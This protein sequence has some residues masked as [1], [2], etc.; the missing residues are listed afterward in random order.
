M[1][2][3]AKYIR[4]IF[5]LNGKCCRHFHI[6]R[7]LENCE[8]YVAQLTVGDIGK[9]FRQTFIYKRFQYFR[10]ANSF[11]LGMKWE[12]IEIVQPSCN[13]AHFIIQY[14]SAT[15]YILCVSAIL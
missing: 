12:R 3:H 7:I 13:H 6:C 11:F 8:L 1:E 2:L 15:S 9:T 5:K 14:V 10:F 4:T